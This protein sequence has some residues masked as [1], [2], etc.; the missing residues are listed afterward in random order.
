MSIS[1]LSTP[2]T[3][4]ENENVTPS[5]DGGT[6]PDCVKLN[7]ASTSADSVQTLAAMTTESLLRELHGLVGLTVR[8]LL[9]AAEVYGQLLSRG[10]VVSLESAIFRE[11]VP[12]IYA[13]TLSPQ[14]AVTFLDQPALLKRVANLPLDVQRHLADGGCLTVVPAVGQAPTEMTLRELH[15]S[16]LTQ[17]VL[18]AGRVL[19][20]EQQRQQLAA[21]ARYGK[22][23]GV[24]ATKTTA[25]AAAGPA[26]EEDAEELAKFLDAAMREGSVSRPTPR[27]LAELVVRAG[28][29]K[30]R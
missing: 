13:G 11:V 19:T 26:S 9:R 27:W 24:F 22:S 29:S 5:G 8:V 20:V 18:H 23:T 17:V 1:E 12:R 4:P 10:V 6:A 28:W 14:A 21:R 2:P 15:A 16:G 30:V 3:L 25:T 7:S